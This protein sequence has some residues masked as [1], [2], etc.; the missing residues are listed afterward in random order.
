MSTMHRRLRLLLVAVAVE[1]AV[2]SATRIVLLVRFLHGHQ[3]AGVVVALVGLGWLPV[4]T[5]TA[6]GT[7]VA[8]YRAR[9]GLSG[10]DRAVAAVAGTSQDW[11]W[12]ADTQLRFTYCGPRV[13]GLLGYQPDDLIGVSMPSLMGPAEATRGNDILADARTALDG[14][15]DQ[16][17]TWRHADGHLVSLEGSAAP[18]RDESGALVGFRGCRRLATTSLAVQRSLAAARDRLTAALATADLDIALQPIASLATGRLVGV[19]ALA[20]FRDGRGPDAWFTEAR[21]TGQALALDKTA[22]LAALDTIDH[23]PPDCYLSV[24]ASPEVLTDPHFVQTLADSQVPMERLVVE[25]T[26]HVMIDRYDHI[27]AALLPLR[28][29]GLRLAIDDTGAGY[30]SFRHVLQLHPD[31]I[32]VD[33]SLVADLATDPARRALISA[34]VLLARELDASVTG[35]GVETATELTALAALGVDAA[36]GW[37]LARPTIDRDRWAAWQQETWPH[38]VQRLADLTRATI[39]TH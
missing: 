12:E 30:A 8:L 18:I 19:E 7:G 31:I 39:A 21:E 27:R 15:R 20:R 35:E 9:H 28:E 4:L 26:E 10:F 14:W 17:A 13:T 16:E 3:G 29:R 11:I 23:L 2:A 37:L 34:L 36:Q 6:V 1:I 24:N 25:I 38:A 5:L 22:F 33:R 32:K